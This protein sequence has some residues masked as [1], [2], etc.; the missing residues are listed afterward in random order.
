MP[1]ITNK[2][3]KMKKYV[4]HVEVANKSKPSAD[5]YL[6]EME[7]RVRKSGIIGPKDKLVVLPVYDQGTSLMV[8]P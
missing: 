7:Q 1:V 3:Y 6:T 4:L 2:D 8:L 5:A